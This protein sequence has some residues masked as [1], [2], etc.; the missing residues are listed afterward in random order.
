VLWPTLQSLP[1]CPS[2]SGTILVLHRIDERSI[3]NLSRF[4]RIGRRDLFEGSD[5]NA[6]IGRCEV[7]IGL[8]LVRKL[9]W[10]FWPWFR[11]P[12]Q[13]SKTDGNSP[14]VCGYRRSDSS[15]LDILD[16]FSVRE[17]R[18]KF[19]THPPELHHPFGLHPARARLDCLPK[20]VDRSRWG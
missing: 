16:E 11:R 15:P 2:C 1:T 14:L 8:F 5:N 4:F 7:R 18:D 13:R 20:L 3:L 10:L 12:W 9:G 6:N 17:K 19:S